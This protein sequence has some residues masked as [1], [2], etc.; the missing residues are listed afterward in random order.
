MAELV[1]FFVGEVPNRLQSIRDYCESGD[2]EGVQR[3]A[4]QLKGACAGY[5]FEQVGLAAAKLEE[6]LKDEATLDD[7]RDQIDE[8]TELLRRVVS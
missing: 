8:L 1:E 4:H 5:G 7:V 2:R 3:I 6:P